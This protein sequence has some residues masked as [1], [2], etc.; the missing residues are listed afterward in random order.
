MSKIYSIFTNSKGATYLEYTFFWGF[1]FFV[2]GL[3]VASALSENTKGWPESFFCHS[4][5]VKVMSVAS[6]HIKSMLCYS[7]GGSTPTT[8]IRVTPSASSGKLVVA[9]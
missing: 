3:T 4:P 2:F 1:V 5:D 8:P 9:A 7:E 6:E